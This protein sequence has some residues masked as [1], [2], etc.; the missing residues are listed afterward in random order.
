A[1]LLASAVICRQLWGTEAGFLAQPS[2]FWRLRRGCYSASR[3]DPTR[4]RRTRRMRARGCLNPG[5]LSPRYPAW[6][7]CAAS[8]FGLARGLRRLTLPREVQEDCPKR[9]SSSKLKRVS[10]GGATSFGATAPARL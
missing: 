2:T 9:A 10:L 5:S 3:Q 7:I 4:R 6:R 8:F 1:L